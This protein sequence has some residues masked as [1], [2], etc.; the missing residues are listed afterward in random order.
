MRP[1]GQWKPITL[2]APEKKCFNKRNIHQ[3]RHKHK[4]ILHKQKFL[5]KFVTIDLLTIFCSSSLASPILSLSL[6][7]TTNMSPC[8]VDKDRISPLGANGSLK[9]GFKRFS[10]VINIFLSLEHE[11]WFTEAK[12]LSSRKGIW[13]FEHL[14]T[15]GWAFERLFGPG[16]REVEQSNLAPGRMLKCWVDHRISFST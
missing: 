12:N 3:T 5:S 1:V 14:S 11:Q 16:R 2:Q 10:R 9:R 7:S 15:K 4:S 6:L 13:A 8:R